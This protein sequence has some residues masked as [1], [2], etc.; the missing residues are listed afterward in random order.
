MSQMARHK[1]A[2]KAKMQNGKIKFLSEMDFGLGVD[3]VRD[4]VSR[5]LAKFQSSSGTK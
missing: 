5:R 4:V 3:M 1:K 2:R